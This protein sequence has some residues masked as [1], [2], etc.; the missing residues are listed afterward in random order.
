LAPPGFRADEIDD[1]LAMSERRE[2]ERFELLAQVELRRGGQLETFTAINI[3]AGGVLLLND[4]NV[5]CAIGEE[6]R[7]RFDVPQLTPAFVIDATIVRIVAA[8]SKP[9]VFA[10]MWTSSDAAAASSLAQMLWSL[11]QT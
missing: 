7:V 8:T 11:K 9:A 10:A 6:I 3:S 4:R 5:A 1:H 2:H